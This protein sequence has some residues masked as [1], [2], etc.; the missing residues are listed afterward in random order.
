MNNDKLYYVQNVE[1]GYAMNSV[2]WWKHD[3]NGYT[4]DVRAA[5]KFTEHEANK[6]VKDRNKYRMYGTDYIDG[7]VQYHVDAQ[8]LS[9]GRFKPH[10]MMGL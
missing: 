3:D 9:A 7:L 10:T 2:F 5:K 4:C 6:L 1:R 8:D